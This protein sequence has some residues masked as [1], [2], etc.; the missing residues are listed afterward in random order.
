MHIQ[1]NSFWMRIE[2]GL[3]QASCE[4]ALSIPTYLVFHK[5]LMHDDVQCVVLFLSRMLIQICRMFQQP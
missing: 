4:C 1:F 2:I 3:Q 5:L